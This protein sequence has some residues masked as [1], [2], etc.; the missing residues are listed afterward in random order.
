MTVVESLPAAPARSPSWW[1]SSPTGRQLRALVRNPTAMFGAAIVVLVLLC[2]LLAPLIAPYDPLAISADALAPPSAAHPLGTDDLGR[3]ILSR[4]LYG[5]RVTPLVGI[6]PVALSAAA[7]VVLGLLAGFSR[8]LVDNVIMRLIDVLLAFPG[9][10]LAIAVV[11]VLGPGLGNA[12]I[13]VGIAGVPIFARVVRGL[14][15]V[16]REKEYVAAAR[17]CGARAPR[18]IFAEVLPNVAAPVLVLSTVSVAT[19]ILSTAGLS[20]LGLGAQPP[21]PEWGAM[22]SQGRDYLTDQWWIATFPGLAIAIAVL[23]INLLGDGLRDV[24]DPRL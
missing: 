19:A 18:L 12:M 24:L 7:G 22:L 5:A 11:A 17:L 2:G 21:Q 10:V 23:G 4:V 16:E 14:V 6:A 15:L 8:G 9:I 1:R 13:A 3:D 20:F